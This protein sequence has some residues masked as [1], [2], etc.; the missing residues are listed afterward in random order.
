MATNNK[1]YVS[2]GNNEFNEIELVYPKIFSGTGDDHM[3]VL[4][5]NEVYRILDNSEISKVNTGIDD[6]I[7]DI[8]YSGENMF[9][10]CKNSVYCKGPNNEGQLG[11]GHYDNVKNFIIHE[12]LTDKKGLFVP[13]NK[14]KNAN[15]R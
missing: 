5:D 4:S 3:Y 11:L 8:L 2:N 14:V 6:T 1:V 13:K 9:V 7:I 12:F 15:F 10:V